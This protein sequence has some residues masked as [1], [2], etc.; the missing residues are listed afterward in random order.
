M[1][2]IHHLQPVTLRTPSDLVAIL[3]KK[4]GE[5][6]VLNVICLYDYVGEGDDDSTS[7]LGALNLDVEAKTGMTNGALVFLLE[8]AKMAILKGDF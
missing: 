8:R 2:N 1:S 5:E 4:L 6:K 7:S 3:G